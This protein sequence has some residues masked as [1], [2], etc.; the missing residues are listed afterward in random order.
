[1]QIAKNAAGEFA[2]HQK[3]IS[4]LLPRLQKAQKGEAVEFSEAEKSQLQAAAK[5]GVKLLGLSGIFPAAIAEQLKTMLGLAGLAKNSQVLQAEFDL[6]PGVQTLINDYQIL[7]NSLSVVYNRTSVDI[8]TY[9]T[10]TIGGHSS[11]YSSA[12]AAC[13]TALSDHK[14]QLKAIADASAALWSVI[15]VGAFS[16]ISTSGKAL[17]ALTS[18]NPKIAEI[19]S[20]TLSDVVNVA[21]DILQAGSDKLRTTNVTIKSPAGITGT[22]PMIYQIELTKEFYKIWQHT[23][24][25]MVIL[26]ET[27]NTIMGM[28]NNLLKI[29]GNRLPSSQFKSL[30]MQYQKIATDTKMLTTAVDQYSPNTTEIDTAIW[31][32]N[33]SRYLWSQT[34]PNFKKNVRVAKGRAGYKANETQY[35][36]LSWKLIS[37]WDEL[38]ILLQA[39]CNKGNKEEISFSSWELS[40]NDE[41]DLLVG[42][43]NCYTL[44]P[45]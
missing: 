13:S 37:H 25:M 28:L 36:S 6:A 2:P 23:L 8:T 15:T 31:I 30:E 27:I 39:G 24:S 40:W 11:A 16:Y 17:A 19:E 35:A 1:M 34:I 41:I 42:W 20:K 44:P 43:A 9:I 21:E 26:Q 10:N 5:A 3:A 7:F 12:Y 38:G 18:I 14:D 32:R 33:Y 4:A 29:K 45:F 22:L